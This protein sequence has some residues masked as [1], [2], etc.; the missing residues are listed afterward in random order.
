MHLISGTFC[1]TPLPWLPVLSNIEL[2]AIRRKAAT[3]KLVEKIV[4]H[5]SSPIEPDIFN[6]PLLRL[7]SRKPLWLDLQP[8]D[9]KSRWRHNW[10][11]AQVVSSSAVMVF[12]R[13]PKT[14]GFK[15]EP[16]RNRNFL[17]A[18]WRFFWNFEYGP[19]RSQKCATIM[20]MPDPC[21]LK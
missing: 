21:H 6:P 5:D 8:A 9:I 15:A 3:D 14:A 12:K 11:L 18:M 19:A 10:K 2:P 16:N 4:K 13:K 17:A 7:T 20:A 1:S